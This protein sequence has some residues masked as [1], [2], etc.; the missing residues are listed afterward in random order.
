MIIQ[1]VFTS[2]FLVLGLIYGKLFCGKICPFGMI[3]DLVFKIPF[4]K[5]IKTF[6]GDK[7]LRYLKYVLLIYPLISLLFTQNS[8][9]L[10]NR[11]S[12]DF[13]VGKIIILGSCVLFSI[14]LFRPICKY[15][16]P[17]GALFSIFN[18]IAPYKYRVRQSECIQ[19]NKCAKVCKMNIEQPYKM[20]NHPECIRCGKCKKICPTNVIYTGFKKKDR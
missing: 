13:S 12:E 16:C 15:L 1:I 3:Q 10:M 7:I 2:L 5:K 18:M 19:C 17:L 11:S 4:P 9:E 14:L 6:K 8:E 20:P